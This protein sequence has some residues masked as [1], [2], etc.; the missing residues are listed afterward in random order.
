MAGRLRAHIHKGLYFRVTSMKILTLTVLLAAFSIAGLAARATASEGSNF[1]SISLKDLKKAMADGTV[2]LL[3]CNGTQTFSR[4][5]I[6]GAIDFEANKNNLAN[7]L[8]AQKDALIVSY[9]GNGN[10]PKYKEGAE[11]AA[12]LGYTQVKH[13]VPGIRGWTEAGEAIESVANSR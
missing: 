10:C 11:A 9:C 12:R 13:Y 7:L 4:N 8:P 3:D 5:H 6:P 1:S 2:T